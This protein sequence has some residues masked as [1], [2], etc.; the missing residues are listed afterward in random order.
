[1]PVA[2]CAAGEGNLP[3]YLAKGFP[4]DDRKQVTDW[5][6]VMKY[7][8]ETDP[9]HR[10]LTVHPTGIGRLSARHATD[11]A[12]LLDIDMLQTPHFASRDAVRA[13]G[14]H[15]AAIVQR[16]TNHARDRRRGGLRDARRFATHAVDPPNVLA[17]HDER[18][19]SHLTGANGIWQCNR[20]GQPHGPSPHHARPEASATAKFRGTTR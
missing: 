20:K 16:F 7:I 3:W 6:A 1:M 18:G 4:Y 10:P 19:R 17:L 8:R 9:Y 15:H 13:D 12:A 14:Q 11:D 2:W 5:T